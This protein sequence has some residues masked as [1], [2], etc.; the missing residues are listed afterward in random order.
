MSVLLCLT[1]FS[2]IFQMMRVR[3]WATVTNSV[4]EGARLTLVTQLVW[5]SSARSCAPVD[6]S[7][8]EICESTAGEWKERSGSSIMLAKGFLEGDKIVLPTL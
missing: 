6:A 4:P 7:H 3:S 8:S 2:W 1:F 5:P